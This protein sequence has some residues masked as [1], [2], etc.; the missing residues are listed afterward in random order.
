MGDEKRY[1]Y[2][3]L[4]ALFLY[5][6]ITIIGVAVLVRFAPFLAATFLVIGYIGA[7]LLGVA[8]RYLHNFCYAKVNGEK[9]VS[10]GSV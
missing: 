3:F 4:G 9:D 8:T 10:Q 1:Y 5:A 2:V 7:G 6:L